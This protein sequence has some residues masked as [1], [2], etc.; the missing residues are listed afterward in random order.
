MMTN[1][2]EQRIDEL[3]AKM[4]LEEKAGQ[5]NQLSASPV[6]GFEISAEDAR[7]ML[8]E[9]SITQEQY[10]SIVMGESKRQAE[11]LIRQGKAG[12]M[13]AVL[14]AGSIN[15][16]QRI[17]VEESR[18]GIPLLV[19]L[20]VVHGLKTIFP[21]PLAEA[22]TFDE[23]CWETSARIAAQAAGEGHTER[24]SR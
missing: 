10:D 7:L 16:L 9:G 18:L 13:I 24:Q 23:Q 5:M 17:A 4:T 8:E 1:N 20:D 3:L 6:G 11:D 2:I 14:D 19:A 22:C 21:I 12:S 15:R